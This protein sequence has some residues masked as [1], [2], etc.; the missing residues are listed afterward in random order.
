LIPTDTLRRYGFV[1]KVPSND[2]DKPPVEV[3][4]DPK[5]CASCCVELP[6]REWMR[7]AAERQ[8]RETMHG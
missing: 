5:L 7:D 1:R 3:T 6:G 2:P 4:Y 8:K